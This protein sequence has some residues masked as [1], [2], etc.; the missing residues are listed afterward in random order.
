[1]NP[2]RRFPD[3]A[4]SLCGLAL[5]CAAAGTPAQMIYKQVDA[6][7]RVT[8]TDRPD[9]SLPAQSITGAAPEAP[10]APAR[11]IL[12]TSQRLATI[13]AK[14]AGRRLAQAQVMRSE[15]ADLLRSDWIHGASAGVPGQRYWQRQEKLRVLVEQAQQRAIETRHLL[16]ARS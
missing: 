6:A 3:I 8:F 15:G 5:L 4:S 10:R 12:M 9:S 1:M 11:V 16:L 13:N 7:G 2:R 14:E